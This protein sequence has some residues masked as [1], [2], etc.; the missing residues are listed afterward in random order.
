[1]M[2]CLCYIVFIQTPLTYACHFGHDDIV[3]YLLSVG[4]KPHPV[5]LQKAIE[6]GYE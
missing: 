6:G 4:A 3:H 5:A 1:M 2:T